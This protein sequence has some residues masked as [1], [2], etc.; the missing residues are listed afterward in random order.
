MSEVR[1]DIALDD[2]IFAIYLVREDG[3]FLVV[4]PDLI[5]AL[6][7]KCAYN[8]ERIGNPVRFSESLIL[9][10]LESIS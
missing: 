5:L 2:V 9:I 7:I 6:V 8:G 1:A 4:L 3:N 10:A